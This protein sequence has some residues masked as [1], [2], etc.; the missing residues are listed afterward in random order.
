MGREEGARNG[1]TEGGE[2]T[3]GRGKAHESVCWRGSGEAPGDRLPTVINSVREN[4]FSLPATKSAEA[5]NAAVSSAVRQLRSCEK[6]IYDL[7]TPAT[8]GERL[9]ESV[10]PFPTPGEGDT[11]SSQSLSPAPGAG[12]GRGLGDPEVQGL[13]WTPMLG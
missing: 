12:G 11:N 1:Q 6:A 2:R 4:R 8:T 5:D 10:P 13:P 7:H 3:R 9:W